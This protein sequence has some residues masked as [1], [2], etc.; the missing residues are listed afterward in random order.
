MSRAEII[1]KAELDAKIAYVAEDAARCG[2]TTMGLQA[3]LRDSGIEL[4]AENL[5]LAQKAFNEAD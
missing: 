1:S 5:E 4:S 2:A 3:M